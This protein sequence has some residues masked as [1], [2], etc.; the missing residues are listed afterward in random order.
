VLEAGSGQPHQ[1]RRPPLHRRIAG[2]SDHLCTSI[3][4]DLRSE[5]LASSSDHLRVCKKVLAPVLLRGA[6][7]RPLKPKSQE[8]RRQVALMDSPAEATT[9]AMGSLTSGGDHL[10]IDGS[11]HLRTGARRLPQ[12]AKR[13]SLLSPHGSEDKTIQ[14][15]GVR[16]LVWPPSTASSAGEVVDV[17]DL[18]TARPSPV[19]WTD[20]HAPT[21]RQEAVSEAAPEPPEPGS[22]ARVG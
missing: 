7:T 11:G 14:E 19:Q 21:K 13:S 8:T 18:R 22:Q 3:D 16:R 20:S 9:S 10:S 12:R 2:D 4:N 15:R 1:R 17:A 5:R 6:T